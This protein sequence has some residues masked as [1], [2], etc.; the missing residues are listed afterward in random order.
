MS[1]IGPLLLFGMIVVGALIMIVVLILMLLQFKI[2]Q[3]TRII[4]RVE[5]EAIARLKQ[6]RQKAGDQGNHISLVLLNQWTEGELNDEFLDHRVAGEWKQHLACC[7]ECREMV[8]FCR[9]ERKQKAMKK[10]DKELKN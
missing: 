5:D 3:K 6:L 2:K 9:G 7:P 4:S 1:I 8:E 10:L